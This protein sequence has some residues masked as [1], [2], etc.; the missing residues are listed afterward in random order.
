MK[1]LRKLVTHN[2]L[3]LVIVLQI[4]GD[5]VQTG[6]NESRFLPSRARWVN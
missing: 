3:K 2:T 1:L 6:N 5:V 4:V